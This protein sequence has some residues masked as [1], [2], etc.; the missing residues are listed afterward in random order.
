MGNKENVIIVLSRSYS[1]GLSVIRSL[2]SAGYTVDLIASVHKPGAFKVAAASKFIRNFAEVV[3]KKVKDGAD[4]GLIDELLKYVGKY[5]NK[6]II[7]PTDDYTASVMDLNRSVLA[8]HFIMPTIV[9]GGNG[10]MSQLMDKT[11]QGA[12]ARE[13]GIMTPREWSF[14]LGD[15]IKIPADMTYP[16][17]CKPIESI[18]G[19]KKEMAVCE[20]RDALLGHLKKLRKSFSH[21]S[22]L[23]QEFLDIDYEIDL[24]GVCLDQE[25]IIPAI[26]RKT[27]VAQY[28][29][30]VTLSGRVVPLDELGDLKGKIL[31]MLQKFHYYGMFDM[32]LNVVGGEIYFNEVNLR[33]GGPN[34]AY[35]MSGVNLP[36]LY[37][38]EVLGGKHSN[39][40]A[41]V[42]EYGKTFIYEK[43]AWEDFLHGYMTKKELNE[44]LRT[45]DIKLLYYQDDPDPWNI[46]LQ[47]S[48]LLRKKML[49]KKLRKKVVHLAKVI[50]LGILL[51]PAKLVKGIKKLP[52]NLKK[53]F[54]KA[55]F[56]IGIFLKGYPQSKRKNRRNPDSELPRVLLAGRNYCSNLCMAR[57]LGE[58]GYEVEVLRVYQTKPQ[59]RNLMKKIQPDAYSKYV[60][61]FHVCISN[62]TPEQIVKTLIKLAD[63]KRKM[64][65]I[66]TDDLVAEIADEN[67]K[68]LAKYYYMPNVGA[69]AGRLGRLMSK[70]RQKKLAAEFGLPVVNSCRIKTEGGSFKI[71]KTVSYPC[72]VKPNISKN[73]SKSKMK[74]CKNKKQLQATL[75]EFSKKKDI[76]V[77]VEDYINIVREYSI[78]GLSTR[79]AVVSPGF[80]VA[81]KGGHKERRGVAMTGRVLSTEREQQLIDDVTRF[82]GT[83]NYEGLFDVD[84]VEDNNGKIYF[85]ELNLRYGASGYA[86]TCSGAN[87][88]GMFADYML[89]QTPIDTSCSID[90]PGRLFIS[91]KVMLDEYVGGF[92]TKEQMKKYMGEAEIHF[93]KHPQ[94]KKP[95]RHFRKFF[96]IGQLSI[97][98]TK[99]LNA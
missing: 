14:F 82:V 95:Y 51:S 75:Q 44:S 76:D 7:F 35:F 23:V 3:S 78:L 41:C 57:S 79:E 92:I 69:K 54:K 99:I 25:I 42:A 9:D 81:E 63:Q 87:L 4:T 50:V 97:L 71:P 77:L 58:A 38:K 29:K 28:E 30:G 16:C 80:F 36:A 90:R 96:F 61:A 49:R 19:Y 13:A 15:K 83:L 47:D 21:R 53:I 24:S 84:L 62:R 26:I 73:S 67:M 68:K 64:L 98:Y 31:S 59:W 45:A 72:F 6:P 32:E 27:R 43:V 18:S 70:N 2:G 74:K 22:I 94:D 37:V 93:V 1:T 12:L 55:A 17:F 91:E 10:S 40:E 33:S 65:L 89:K 39:E 34:F 88:P 85:V 11:V 86:V 48:K 60:K 20:N 52:H 56:N 46:F 66:P 8:E 5:E